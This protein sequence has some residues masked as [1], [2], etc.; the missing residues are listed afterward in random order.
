MVMRSFSRWPV[1]ATNVLDSRGDAG[2]KQGAANSRTAGIGQ[3]L[4]GRL[5]VFGE[6]FVRGHGAC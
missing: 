5:L 2:L 1:G 6:S 4:A 3:P